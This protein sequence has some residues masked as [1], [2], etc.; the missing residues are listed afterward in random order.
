MRSPTRIVDTRIAGLNP[1]GGTKRPPAK[2]SF[3]VPVA[4][5]PAIGRSD[6]SAVVINATTVDT[7]SIGYITVGTA[8]RDRPHRQPPRTS[9][10]NVVR[11]SQMLANHAI[12]PVSTR[13]FIDVHRTRWASP[14]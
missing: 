8:V 13:G 9:T 1:L 5:K 12:V 14:R 3:E 4:T 6:V 2:S 7:L 11:P 10:M